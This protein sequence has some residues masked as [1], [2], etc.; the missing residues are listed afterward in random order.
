M[1]MRAGYNWSHWSE[2]QGHF[3]LMSEGAVLMPFQSYQ[4]GR[5]ANNEFDVCNLLRFGH[6]ANRYPH[7]WPD[8]NVLDHAFGPSVDYAWLSVGFPDW[9]ID[10]GTNPDFAPPANA[11]VGKGQLR[12]LAEGVEQQPGAF[13]WDRQVVFVKRQDDAGT[14][15][16]VFRDAANGAGKLASWMNFNLIGTRED[17]AVKGDRLTVATEW[18]VTLNMQFPGAGPL[19]PD[20]DEQRFN[21]SGWGGGVGLQAFRDGKPVSRNWVQ[22]DGSTFT[23]PASQNVFERHVLLR[24]PQPAGLDRIW[25]LWPGRDGGTSPELKT[26]APGVLKIVS[27]GETVYVFLDARH[28]DYAD[29]D[30]VF[31]GR[32]GTVR[33]RGGKVTLSLLGGPGRV[34]Y[35]GHVIAGGASFERTLAVGDLK[36]G[37]HPEPSS[38]AVPAFAPRL[39]GHGETAPGVVKAEADGV[40]EYLADAA[41]PVDFADGGVRIRAARASVTIAP[42]GIRLMALSGGYA[43]LVVGNVAVRGVGPFDLTFRDD[44]IRGKVEGDARTLVCTW[45]QDITRPMYRMDGRRWYAGFGDNHTIVKGTETPQFAIAFGVDEGR[46][47]VEI[48]EW[49]Y[50]ALPAVPERV[51]V[52]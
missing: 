6:P 28:L 49:T 50:P 16:F 26:M 32:A 23:A 43:E 1:F 2:D 20:L 42:D 46:H 27:A 38:V 33:L 10:P 36:P 12:P 4:Y 14:D 21:I 48:A 39:S 8:A 29:D 44:A 45:P 25:L 47:E 7:S 34:G 41:V 11:P 18:P 13:T 9:Y 40:V 37:V 31:A 5:S 3:M 22:G 51:A 24:I 17:V 19:A 52:K 30:V 15:F 35:R